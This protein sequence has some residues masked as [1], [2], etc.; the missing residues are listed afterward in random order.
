MGE[1]LIKIKEV[2]PVVGVVSSTWRK[3]SK[4]GRAPAPIKRGRCTFWKESEV[5]AW[6]DGS[7]KSHQE[8]QPTPAS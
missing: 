4:E 3:W 2:L 7:W 6:I 1:K 5:T 8:N